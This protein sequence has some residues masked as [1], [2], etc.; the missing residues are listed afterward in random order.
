MRQ[1]MS[2]IYV[3]PDDAILGVA[4]RAVITAFS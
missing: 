2:V 1:K 3:T 4:G